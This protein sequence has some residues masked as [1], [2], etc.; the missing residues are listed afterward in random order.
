MLNRKNTG[1][2]DKNKKEILEK[3][4]IIIDGCTWEI[5]HML[6]DEKWMLINTN[7]LPIEATQEI[8]DKY[9]IIGDSESYPFLIDDKPMEDE[10]LQVQKKTR[11]TSGLPDI[12]EDKLKHEQQ[13]LL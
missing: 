1:F 9:E 5:R 13:N 6:F 11:N 4:L 12:P 2:V 8:F 3:D 10:P 7:Q